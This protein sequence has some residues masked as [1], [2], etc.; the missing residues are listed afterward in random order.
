MAFKT[1][2]ATTGSGNVVFEGDIFTG[3]TTPD[4]KNVVVRFV[5]NDRGYA[6][7]AFGGTKDAPLDAAGA[8]TLRDELS[9][10]L[11][12]KAATT[13]KFRALSS[14]KHFALLRERDEGPL[15]LEITGTDPR[16]GPAYHRGDAAEMRKIVVE[17]DAVL[18]AIADAASIK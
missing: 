9:E 2:V 15:I 10:L 6:C 18:K 4:G 11:D 8:K 5:T 1:F 7:A 14:Q 12:Q 13:G 17:F 16:F 3:Q